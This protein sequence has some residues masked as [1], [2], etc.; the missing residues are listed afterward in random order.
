[1][2]PKSY[3]WTEEAAEDASLDQAEEFIRSLFPDEAAAAA[4]PSSR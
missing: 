3:F 2:S 4:V 1:M